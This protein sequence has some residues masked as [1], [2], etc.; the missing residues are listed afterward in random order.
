M[1]EKYY[2]LYFG[3]TGS[4]NSAEPKI[5]LSDNPL[6]GDYPTIHY[7]GVVGLESLRKQFKELASAG[8]SNFYIHYSGR[9]DCRE[10]L[11]YTIFWASRVLNNVVGENSFY[12][13][14]SYFI[15]LRD[16]PGEYV[17]RHKDFGERFF[18]LSS[19]NSA[20]QLRFTN[21]EE[22][23]WVAF[24]SSNYL[25]PR[26]ALLVSVLLWLFRRKIDLIIMKE[27][28]FG[29]NY[30][31]L[32]RGLTVAFLQN[33]LWGDG[34]NSSFGLSLFCFA[35]AETS[36]LFPEADGPVNATTYLGFPF[37]LDYMEKIYIPAF[38]DDTY[39]PDRRFSGIPDSTKQ[40]LSKLL[41]LLKLS[42]NLEK[43]S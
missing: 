30:K 28:A 9:M 19:T 35:Y 38:P 3:V 25:L 24:Y 21:F 6:K 41:R 22:N 8:V 5:S 18:S 11:L 36:F 40:S 37:V 4:R 7:G 14:N 29:G 34:Q 42:Q 43:G 16:C 32:V 1:S 33:P 27:E 12:R 10:S 20:L 26:V 17:E 39:I 23:C 2:E 13:I 15:L 31:S